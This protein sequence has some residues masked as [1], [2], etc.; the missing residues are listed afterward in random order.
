MTIVESLP[1]VIRRQNQNKYFPHFYP[2]DQRKKLNE[3]EGVG[4]ERNFVNSRGRQVRNYF[5][6]IFRELRH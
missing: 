2:R 3:F 5:F 1:W 4:T 6:E